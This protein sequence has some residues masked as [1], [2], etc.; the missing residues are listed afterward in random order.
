MALQSRI[1][2]AILCCV[3]GALVA[4]AE[5]PVIIQVHVEEGA[6]AVYGPGSRATRGLSVRV[7]DENGRPVESALVSFQL[8]TEGSS[9]WFADG[10]RT[11]ITKTGRDGKATVWGMQWN[12]TIGT[13]VIKVT[14]RKGQAHGGV[15]ISQFIADVAKTSGGEGTFSAPHKSRMKWLLIG[16]VGAGAAAGLAFSRSAPKAAVVPAAVSVLQIGNPSIIVGHP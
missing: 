7:S 16:S 13:V 8:P 4:R 1:S 5:D 15:E 12:R 3:L 10:G 6:G 9:G 2:R 14:A 11:A